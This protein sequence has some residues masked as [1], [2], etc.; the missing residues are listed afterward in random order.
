MMLKAEQVVVDIGKAVRPLYVVAGDEPLL[1]QECCDDIRAA[2]RKAGYLQRDLFHAEGRFD[3]KEVLFSAN[4][5]SLFAEQKLIEVRLNS[6][7]LGDAGDIFKSYAES[8]PADTVLMLVMPRVDRQAQK[9]KWF[10]TLD[11]LGA[12]VQIWPVETRSLPGWL[13]QRCRRV[14]LKPTKEAMQVLADKTEGNLLAAVQ[15]IEMLRLISTDDS[16]DEDLVLSG[17]SDSSR[18]DVFKMIDAALAGD[19]IRTLRIIASLRAEDE[20][21]VP[22]NFMVAR[23]VRA[24][25]RIARDAATSGVPAALKR[26]RVWKNR[27]AVV[28]RAVS[29]AR[30]GTFSALAVRLAEIDGMAKGF[31]PGDPWQALEDVMLTLAGHGNAVLKTA[32]R[33]PA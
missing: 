18:F 4:S 21:V 23:E 19:M 5:M 33:H 20:P 15:E 30:P 13:A 16:V 6:S 32:E 2:L 25:D 12:I 29:R 24:L 26:N 3:W 1:V 28:S 14:G 10:K 8:P 17:V 9:T 27:E 7:R 31:A 22:V 11:A